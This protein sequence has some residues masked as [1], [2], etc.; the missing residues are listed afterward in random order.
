MGVNPPTAQPAL[1]R[2][3]YIVSVGLDPCSGP[4]GCRIG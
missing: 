1:A 4:T 2:L 3:A